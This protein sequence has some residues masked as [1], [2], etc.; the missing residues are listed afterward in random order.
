MSGSAEYWVGNSDLLLFRNKGY[1]PV[2]LAVFL[3]RSP[4]AIMVHKNSDIKTVNDFVGKKLLFEPNSNELKGWLQRADLSEKNVTLIYESHKLARFINKEVAEL[5]EE[6]NE[7]EKY[8][9]SSIIEPGYYKER[10]WMHIADT[11]LELG[12]LPKTVSFDGFFY[13]SYISKYPE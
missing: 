4:L 6:A 5:I 10:R 13:E 1:Q 12:M 2:L 7:I 11:Y 9:E 8:M 3:Q